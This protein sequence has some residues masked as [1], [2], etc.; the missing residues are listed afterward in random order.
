M[1][2]IEVAASAKAPARERLAHAFFA[3]LL[4]ADIVLR[5]H[6]ATSHLRFDRG[7]LLAPFSLTDQFLYGP[8]PD[9]GRQQLL[10][11]ALLALVM[12]IVHIPN[13]IVAML[14]FSHAATALFSSLCLIPVYLIVRRLLS[15]WHALA[16]ALL[17]AANGAFAIESYYYNPTQVY[18][19]LF[20]CTLLCLLLPGWRALLS[21]AVL[22]GF[23]Y[24]IRHEGI[25]LV[26]LFVVLCVLRWRRKRQPGRALL[27]AA[28]TAVGLVG[29]VWTAHWWFSPVSYAFLQNTGARDSWWSIARYSPAQVG[30]LLLQCTNLIIERIN[31]LAVIHTVFGVA[32]VPLGAAFL[33]RRNGAIWWGL[34][35]LLLYEVVVF[36]FIVVLPVTD[37]HYEGLQ[38][39]APLERY[40]RYYHV[41]T[42][43]LVALAYAG[44]WAITSLFIRS[45]RCR[46]LLVGTV[47]ILFAV[48]QQ[49]ALAFSYASIFEP[50]DRATYESIY[51]LAQFCRDHG[52]RNRQI[53]LARESGRELVVRGE[54]D[55]GRLLHPVY[56]SILTGHNDVNC[57]HFDLLQPNIDCKARY[58]VET[59]ADLAEHV[60]IDFLITPAP[61]QRAA[62]YGRLVYS[63]PEHYVYE[64]YAGQPCSD[65]GPPRT[66]PQD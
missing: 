8:F 59:V 30:R 62:E 64:V 21:A 17:L 55:L 32:L 44:G 11:P 16:A 2:Y 52:I 27:A 26:I 24:A 1:E 15:A 60:N 13:D 48:Q 35:H 34:A 7:D 40:T 41:W 12:R 51:A 39:G 63:G 46:T 45:T 22:A 6:R 33:A 25:I 43:L 14:K 20:T 54:R 4:V 10:L 38:W 42:P 18:A 29:I 53:V 28:L 58:D 19:F 31:A 49:V 57:W 56:L 50:S 23:S 47:V 9:A 65:A 3:V 66:G 5:I 61:S 36:A 37:Q